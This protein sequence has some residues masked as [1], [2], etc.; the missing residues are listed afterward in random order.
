MK[1]KPDHISQE[2]WDSVESPELDAAFIAGMKRS[3]RG[4]GPQK[5]P[6]KRLVSL[7]LDP[8]IVER[9]RATGPGWQSRINDTLRDHLPKVE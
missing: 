4:R 3:T 2:A 5:A 9:F 8:D 1:R 6:T 7:R